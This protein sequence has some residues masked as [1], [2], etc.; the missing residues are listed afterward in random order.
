MARRD[1]EIIRVNRKFA[2]LLRSSNSYYAKQVGFNIGLP[3]VTEKL[4]EPPMDKIFRMQLSKR[5]R[6]LF[7]IK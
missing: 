7:E 3:R 6:S 1:T 5:R 4:S 2:Q